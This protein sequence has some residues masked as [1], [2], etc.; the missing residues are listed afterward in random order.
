MEPDV[1]ELE[2]VG[3]DPIRREAERLGDLDELRRRGG[4]VPLI[5]RRLGDGFDLR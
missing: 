4:A 5:A 2:A 3:A 1:A